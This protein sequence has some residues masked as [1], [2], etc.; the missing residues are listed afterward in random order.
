MGEMLWVVL[1]LNMYERGC[2]AG[3]PPKQEKTGSIRGR[4]PVPLKFRFML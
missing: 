1:H 2:Q 4:G 3:P